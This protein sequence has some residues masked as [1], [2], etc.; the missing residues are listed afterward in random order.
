MG[1]NYGYGRKKME[2]AFEATAKEYRDAGVPEEVIEYIHELDL[3][4]LNNER[5]FYRRTV[6]IEGVKFS[7]NKYADKSNSPLY[8]KHQEQFQA[9]E[10]RIYDLERGSW[11]EHVDT[12]E[13]VEWLKTLK[14]KDID[15]LTYQIQDGLLQTDI[16]HLLEVSDA[17]ISKRMKR[18]RKDLEKFLQKRLKN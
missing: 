14:P 15:L 2:R 10:V 1:Y 4:S 11:P 16:A 3:E 5:K 13:L 8:K 12:P 17:A 7:D 9:P 18:L 6:F